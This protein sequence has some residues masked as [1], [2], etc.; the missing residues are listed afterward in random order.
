VQ[1]SQQRPAQQRVSGKKRSPKPKP[2]VAAFHDK[3]N[4]VATRR[5]Q[6]LDLAYT[7]PG[8]YTLELSVVDNQGRE[9]K[10]VQKVLITAK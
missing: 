3:V 6:R 10:R 7:R 8:A 4:G 2:L 9:R 5:S 1:L